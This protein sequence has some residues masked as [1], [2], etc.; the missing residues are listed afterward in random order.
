MGSSNHPH[1]NIKRLNFYIDNV[2]VVKTTY[3][4][5]PTSKQWIGKCIKRDIDK[6]LEEKEE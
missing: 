6:W 5:T 2:A 1:K 3:D 4:I